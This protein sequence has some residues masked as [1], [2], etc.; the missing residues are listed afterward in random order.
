[1]YAVQDNSRRGGRNRDVWRWTLM[2]HGW[3]GRRRRETWPWTLVDRGWR[4][5][6]GI[7]FLGQTPS[8]SYLWWEFFGRISLVGFLIDHVVANITVTN[9]RI[10]LLLFPPRLPSAHF[11][12]SR[13]VLRDVSIS[14]T[15]APSLQC[16]LTLLI[17]VLPLYTSQQPD[18]RHEYPPSA[19]ATRICLVTA[20]P[21]ADA[22]DPKWES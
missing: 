12:T 6:W 18:D 13:L 9:Q 3:R 2:D 17:S 22:Q 20:I 4:L 14:S 7:G 5:R 10:C 16:N 19:H 8:F 21:S 1:M 11:R 15:S